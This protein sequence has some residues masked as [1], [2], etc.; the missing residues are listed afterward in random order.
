MREYLFRGKRKDNREWIYGSL[1]IDNNKYYI[2]VQIN[3]PMPTD[4][5]TVYTDDY[6]VMMYE[7]DPETVGQYTGLKDKNGIKIYEEDIVIDREDEVIGKIVWNKEEASFYFSILFEKGTYEEE[8]LN[9]W[10]DEIEVIGNIY[11]NPELL[12]GEK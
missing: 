1:I 2:T 4:K 6:S 10:V 8:K 5:Y 11:D 9:D 7:V 3:Y 12:K